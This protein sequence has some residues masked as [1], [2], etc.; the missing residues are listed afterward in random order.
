MSEIKDLEN[1]QKDTDRVGLSEEGLHALNILMADGHFK[2]QM[3]S[4]RFAVA[5][6]LKE[7]LDISS[8]T[9]QRPAGHMYLQSQIDPDGVIGNAISELNPISK[10]IKYRALEKYADLGVK[11]LASKIER[12]EHIL[13]WMK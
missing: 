11:F 13:Y 1:E 5:V 12:G 9:V 8:H 6:A 10:S 3:A 7:R 4:Y 2:N